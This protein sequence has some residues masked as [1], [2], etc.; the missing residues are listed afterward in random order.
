VNAGRRL[1]AQR[2]A[3]PATSAVPLLLPGSDLFYVVGVALATAM[4]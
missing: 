1:A 3:L 4:R 2:Q